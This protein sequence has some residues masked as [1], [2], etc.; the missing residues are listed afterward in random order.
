MARNSRAS[1]RLRRNEAA[2]ARTSNAPVRI[3]RQPKMVTQ[4]GIT[5]ISGNEIVADLSTT[6]G[7]FVYTVSTDP[8]SLGNSWLNRMAQC[9]NK[10]RYL[11]A[12]L[13]YVPFVS[14]STQG[15]VALA[16]C[17]D[18]NQVPPGN[19]TS[20]SQFANA[21]EGPAWR[22]IASNFVM[23]RKPEFTYS[24]GT[25]GALEDEAPGKFVIYNDN[26]NLGGTTAN[27][28]TCG[29]LYLEY[30]VQLWDRSTFTGN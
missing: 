14:T 24:S 27:P 26:F 20:V 25:T 18:P 16:W 13:R 4:G 30:T 19:L 9:F 8:A 3:Y 22:E 21:I 28:V 29:S 10:F 11:R 1:R 6:N 17:G 15:R 23:P 5:T 7:P 2:A 12:R